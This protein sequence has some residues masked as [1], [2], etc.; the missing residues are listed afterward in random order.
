MVNQLHWA[1]LL[2][3]RKISG[4]TFAPLFL[5]F[6]SSRRPLRSLDRHVLIGPRVRTTTAQAIGLGLSTPVGP[7]YTGPFP[8]LSCIN[9]LSGFLPASFSLLEIWSRGSRTGSTTGCPLLL[10]AL[11]KLRN[12]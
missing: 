8:A 7:L 4:I 12:T 11:Y 10:V 1:P 5:Q 2:S 3:V 9:L 6:L